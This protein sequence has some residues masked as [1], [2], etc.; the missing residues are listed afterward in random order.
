MTTLTL[1]VKE[2]N[3]R[4]AL[5]LML[6]AIP[7]FPDPNTYQEILSILNENPW[8]TIIETT[9]PVTSQ[10]SEFANQTIKDAHLQADQF[11]DGLPSMEMLQQ[12]KKPTICVL[13]RET[14]EKI[15]YEP[16]LQQLQGKIDGLLF[17]WIIPHIENYAYSYKSYGIELVQCAE[18]SM[19]EQEIVHYLSLTEEEPL[20]Y[21]VSAPM[22]GAEIFS[23]EKINQCIK[24]IKKIRPKAKIVAG[25]GIS[26][27][28][29][30]TRLSHM[31]GLDGVIIGTA[32]LEVMKQGVDNVSTFL[33]AI[34]PALSKKSA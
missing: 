12:F 15:G 24:D 29:D 34:T 25:F 33:D 3:D 27:A 1:A 21:L 26:D 31:N 20:I 18:P 7:N 6:Y 11:T 28:D 10:F 9:F 30:I 22:T 23:E 2:A 5:A 16:L 17:E 8:V 13:Y 19:T 32:F 14:L 4:G